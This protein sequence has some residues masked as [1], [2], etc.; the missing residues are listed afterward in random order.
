MSL[1]IFD[2]FFYIHS[3]PFG[4]YHQFGN[5]LYLKLIEKLYM[6]LEQAPCFV[7]TFQYIMT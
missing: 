6:R 2:L 4:L 1:Y 7:I 5:T 3:L